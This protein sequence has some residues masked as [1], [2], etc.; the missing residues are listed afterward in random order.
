M[1]YPTAAAWI[2]VTADALLT[3]DDNPDKMT[4]AR[5]YLGVDLSLSGRPQEALPHLRWVQ[6]NGNKDFLEY[7]LALSELHRLEGK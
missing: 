5:C 4:E 1:N 2:A 6:E 3:L 7:L